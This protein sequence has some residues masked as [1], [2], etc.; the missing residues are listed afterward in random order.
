M[1]QG[2]A[3][4]RGGGHERLGVAALSSCQQGAPVDFGETRHPAGPPGD[5]LPGGVGQGSAT[6][7][8]V[9]VESSRISGRTWTWTD[10]LL[11]HPGPCPGFSADEHDTLLGTYLPGL[12]SLICKTRARLADV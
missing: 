3:R 4:P 5:K 12:G 10:G 2:G 11:G 8:E 9:E 1:C 6:A 7:T